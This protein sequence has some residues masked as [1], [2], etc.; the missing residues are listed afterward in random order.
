MKQAGSTP[1][2]PGSTPGGWCKVGNST[3]LIK[4]P[5]FGLGFLFE[6][7]LLF[8]RIKKHVTRKNR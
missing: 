8:L 5:D 4:I 3:H 1:V 2:R 7:F 6:T